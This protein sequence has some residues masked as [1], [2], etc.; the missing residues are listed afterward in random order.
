MGGFSNDKLKIEKEIVNK[1]DLNFTIRIPNNI[2]QLHSFIALDLKSKFAQKSYW[3]IFEN[4]SLQDIEIISNNLFDIATYILA[5]SLKIFGKLE[6]STNVF[7]NLH[8][9]LKRRDDNLSNQIVPHLINCY[10]ILSIE[11]GLY[12]KNYKKGINYCER[13]LHL[14]P[15][16][17]AAICNMAL[18]QFH[19]GNKEVAHQ[20][21]DKL[22]ELYPKS[23]H[24]L[25][26]VAFFR[27]IEK[28]YQSALRGYKKLKH[29]YRNVTFNVPEVVEFLDEQY[30][31]LK[32]PAF[33]FASGF[34][35]C[36]YGDM[37]SGKNDFKDFLA[38]ADQK[39]HEILIKETN[40]LLSIDFK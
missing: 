1:I 37:Q 5:L 19:F 11:H 36:H 30:N 15:N 9:D 4:N 8:T 27:L 39:E 33:L 13:I 38:K 26:D 25:I 20:Y 32:D 16:N 40:R 14:N 18:Y 10:D 29:K 17:F 28:D 34:L 7:Q 21:I 22:K 24:T 12:R 35:N 6:E 3:K 2:N 31:A 23:D